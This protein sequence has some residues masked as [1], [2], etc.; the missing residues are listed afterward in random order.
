MFSRSNIFE[1]CSNS[2]RQ[3]IIHLLSCIHCMVPMPFHLKQQYY[4]S[5]II[6]IL[7]TLLV[8]GPMKIKLYFQVKF[9]AMSKISLDTIMDVISNSRFPHTDV[10]CNKNQVKEDHVKRPL[11]KFMCYSKLERAKIRKENPRMNQKDISSMLGKKW[12]TLSPAEQQEYEQKAVD[13]KH[14]HQ[15]QFPQYK[16]RPK[17]RGTSTKKTRYFS[18]GFRKIQPA[19]HQSTRKPHMMFTINPE[20]NTFPLAVM[21]DECSIGYNFHNDRTDEPPM[22]NIQN[23]RSEVP[24]DSSKPSTSGS[25]GI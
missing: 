7:V 15:T 11:N 4:N 6:P 19:I 8:M 1:C 21:P 25:P 3:A 24:T 20:P 12:K 14:L 17:R 9:L 10:I 23:V 5:V 18:D 13:L 2:T 22:F 16:Y